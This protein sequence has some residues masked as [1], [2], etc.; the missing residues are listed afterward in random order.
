MS[1]FD[2]LFGASSC[3]SSPG[4][5]M[6]NPANGLPMLSSAVD[7]CGNP[8]GVDLTSPV[9]EQLYGTGVDFNDGVGLGTSNALTDWNDA[10][11]ATDWSSSHDPFAD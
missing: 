9:Y 10:G 3:D 4:E 6:V 8:F 11:C 2:W 7:V 5:P 1:L